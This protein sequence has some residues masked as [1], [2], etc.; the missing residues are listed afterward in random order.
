M[1]S[2]TEQDQIQ[3]Y[4]AFISYRHVD[5]DRKWAKWL[6]N[7]LETYRVPSRLV[8]EGV[9]QRIGKVFRDDDEIPAS[10]DLSRQIELAL[11]GSKFLIVVCSPDT[12][13]SKLF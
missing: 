5:L 13:Q 1:D 8:K 2:K 7:K 4:K 11:E 3:Q 6:I 9:P 12:P 10:S